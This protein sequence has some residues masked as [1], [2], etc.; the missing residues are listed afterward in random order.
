MIYLILAKAVTYQV[1]QSGIQSL[2][3]YSQNIFSKI[4]LKYSQLTMLC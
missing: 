1:F 4:L 2:K 3:F